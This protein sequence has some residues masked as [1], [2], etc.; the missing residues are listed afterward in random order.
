V[1]KTYLRRIS[2]FISRTEKYWQESYRGSGLLA[3]NRPCTKG[4]GFEY[5]F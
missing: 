5:R 3:A 2:W 1:A 4:H